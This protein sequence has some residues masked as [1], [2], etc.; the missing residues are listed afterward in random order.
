[1]R[2]RTARD[3]SA[4]LNVDEFWEEGIHSFR[5]FYEGIRQL[6]VTV[7]RKI[8]NLLNKRIFDCGIVSYKKKSGRHKITPV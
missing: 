3:C 4:Y 7:I 6:W 1:M 8:K 2:I 5:T